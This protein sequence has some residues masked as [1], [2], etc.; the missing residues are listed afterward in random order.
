MSFLYK[1]KQ[2]GS[3]HQH[4]AAPAR[5]LFFNVSKTEASLK[6]LCRTWQSAPKSNDNW[7]PERWAKPPLFSKKTQVTRWWL[8]QPIWKIC[9]SKWIISPGRGENK[10]YLSN[11]HLGEV[12][13][14][15]SSFGLNDRTKLITY[16]IVDKNASI[17]LT[18]PFLFPIVCHKK[19]QDI[20]QNL[21]SPHASNTHHNH[22]L[23]WLLVSTH[24]KNITVVKLEI[25]PK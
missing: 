3:S 10:K 21:S 16:L 22:I 2:L 8:N 5:P 7:C 20:Y 14:K 25:F 23:T 12:H 19:S 9:S 18:T 11:H 24:L 15:N 17:M 1:I 13:F 4:P 6:T